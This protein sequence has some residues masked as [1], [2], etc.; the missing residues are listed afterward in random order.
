MSQGVESLMGAV[1]DS[2]RAPTRD[3]PE[4]DEAATPKHDWLVLDGHILQDHVWSGL[5]NRHAQIVVG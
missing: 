4:P 3:V 1:E 2:W 5:A